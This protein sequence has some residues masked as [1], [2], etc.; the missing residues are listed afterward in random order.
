MTIRV[1]LDDGNKTREQIFRKVYK[2]RSFAQLVENFYSFKT[3]MK[4][5]TFEQLK[6]KERIVLHEFGNKQ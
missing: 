2:G 4:W 6:G 1:R 5:G 3:E